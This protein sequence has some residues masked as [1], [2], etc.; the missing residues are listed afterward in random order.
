VYEFDDSRRPLIIL[1]MHGPVTAAEIAQMQADVEVV[2]ERAAPFS[3]VFDMVDINVPP[4]DEV[5]ELLAWTRTMRVRYAELYDDAV[6]RVPSFTAYHMPSML[7]NLL[8]FFLQMLPSLRNQHVICSSFEE[9][10]TAAEDAASRLGREHSSS[11]HA[12]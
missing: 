1:R 4:R 9:A 11:R 2:V 7:G 12:G 8:R 5:M 10:V 3:I 6:P